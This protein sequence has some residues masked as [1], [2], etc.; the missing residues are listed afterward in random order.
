MDTLWSM[1]KETP[2]KLPGTCYTIK[3]FSIAALR[4]NFYIPELKI[5]LDAGLSANLSP[6]YILITHNHS[7]H[8]ANIPYHLYTCHK[9]MAIFAPAESYTRIDRYI[10]SAYLMSL[11]IDNED[12]LQVTNLYDL[13]PAY[14]GLTEIIIGEKAEIYKNENGEEKVR[15]KGGKPM[16]MEIIK[17]DHSV[18]CVGYGLTE[19][20]LKLKDEYKHL[21]GKEIGALKKSGVDI[22]FE[23]DFPFFCYLGDTS[24]KVLEDPRLEKYVTLMI[25]CTFIL[26][27]EHDNSV[28]TKHMHWE[29]L[30]PYVLSHPKMNF[31]LF[32]FSQRYK[33][34]EI[35]EF[36]DKEFLDESITNV[37]LWIS[38]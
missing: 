17:C 1:W 16:K 35:K 2:M 29:Y 24:P 9:K 37:N 33:P 3:G 31:I 5:M 32:H 18:P 13:I 38:H 25:E 30:K 4:T 23:E 28:Y 7:D 34:D 14:D 11:D 20:R 27:D 10:K 8:T 6:E 26:P 22:N 36:F 19:K 21:Q 12:E 15:Y